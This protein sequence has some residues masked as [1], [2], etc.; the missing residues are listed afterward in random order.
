MLDTAAFHLFTDGA[1]AAVGWLAGLEQFLRDP[2]AGLDYGATCHLLYHLYNW[3][4][5]AALL[6]VGRAD[7][8]ERLVDAEQLLAEGDP[9][10]AGR[11][12]RDLRAAVEGRLS[13]PDLEHAAEPGAA[14][15]PGHG[16]RL[17]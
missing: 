10:A 6:P 8:A 5:F 15:D 1:A 16:P 14:A 7:L 4:Q 13:P 11:I 9:V 2:G 17:L 3:Q 12:L